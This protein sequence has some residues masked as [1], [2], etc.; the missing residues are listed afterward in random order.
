MSLQNWIMFPKLED[1]IVYFYSVSVTGQWKLNVK[2]VF[3]WRLQFQTFAFPTQLVLKDNK[4]NC[5]ATKKLYSKNK[6][7]ENQQLSQ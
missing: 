1:K 6:S 3:L 7:F 4:I 5:Q 2:F